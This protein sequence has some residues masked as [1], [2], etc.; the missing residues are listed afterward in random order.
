MD[1]V[2]KYQERL[3]KWMVKTNDQ[4]LAAFDVPRHRGRG[5]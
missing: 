1:L 2:K 4:G 5:G 3:R